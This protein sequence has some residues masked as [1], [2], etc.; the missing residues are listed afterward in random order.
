[1]ISC[2]NSNEQIQIFTEL[3][4]EL[5]DQ[6][7][8]MNLKHNYANVTI[9]YMYNGPKVKMKVESKTVEI[10]YYCMKSY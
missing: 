1:M 2:K 6:T 3:N 10:L 7:N 5:I 9:W 4:G 8:K